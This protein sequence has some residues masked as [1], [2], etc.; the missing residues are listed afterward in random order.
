MRRININTQEQT[1]D[2]DVSSLE[3]QLKMKGTLSN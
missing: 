3:Q 2:P 1:G